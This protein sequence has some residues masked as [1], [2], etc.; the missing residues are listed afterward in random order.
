MLTYNVTYNLIT[1]SS[2]ARCDN[3]QHLSST[4]Q[5]KF[6]EARIAISGLLLGKDVDVALKIQETNELLKKLCTKQGYTFI[7]NMTLDVTCLN[8]TKLRVRKR[9]GAPSC[10]FH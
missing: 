7:D 8:G 10:P 9:F 1:S 2:Q 4:I 5:N 3:I 6:K